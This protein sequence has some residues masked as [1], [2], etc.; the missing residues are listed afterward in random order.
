MDPMSDPCEFRLYQPGDEKEIVQ[1]LD[2][3]FDGW[4][5]FD[6][7]CSALDHW[8]WKYCD[9]PTPGDRTV[10]LATSD[11]GIVGCIHALSMRVKIGSEI[12]PAQLGADNAI[13]PEFRGMRVTQGMR[14]LQRH[15]E[16]LYFYV[17]VSEIW[18]PRAANAGRRWSGIRTFVRI[19]DVGRQLS[20]MAVERP[21]LM[22]LGYCGAKALAVTRNAFDRRPAASPGL[23]LSEI[24][25][26][27]ER[28]EDFW[29]EVSA[30]YDFIVERRREFLNW[31]YNDARSGGYV[32]MQ[33]EDAGR[34]V[35]YSALK[36]NRYVPEHPTGF[37]CDL[38]ALPNRPDALDLLV[39][40][41]VRRC[42]EAGV[43]LMCCAVPKGHPSAR[44]LGRHGFLNSRMELPVFFGL[45][46]LDS[47]I[48]TAE[49]IRAVAPG[50][51]HFS[52]GDLDTLPVGVPK[53]R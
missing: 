22:Q 15:A 12:V 38:I 36:V 1:L 9:N 4:P 23:T 40:D 17:T 20:A 24:G 41:A 52:L 10:C 35:G 42:D 31:R 46:H 13:H 47:D 32:V 28:I 53:H 37:L 5:H 51:M 29:L 19:R 11:G 44:A 50:R 14:N 48:E 26:F 30:G 45:K 7:E 25:N 3:V 34:V 2:R 33:A 8:Q 49:R 16:G 43:N 39:A 6:L 21:L 27:D 18:V